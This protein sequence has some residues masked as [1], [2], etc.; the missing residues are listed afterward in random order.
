MV[1]VL[2][3]SKNPVKI[4]ATKEA[5]AHYYAELDVQGVSVASGVPDQPMGEQNYEGAI[6][7]AKNLAAEHEADFYVGIEGG[8]ANEY[9]GWTS[10]GVVCVLDKNGKQGVGTSVHFPLPPVVVQELQKGKE[11]GTVIDEIKQSQNE[12]QKSGA[13][14]F[15]TKDAMSRTD[16]YAPAVISALIPFVQSKV[17]D[18]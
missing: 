3:G 8:I 6:T 7:R 10:F 14:G 16:I 18:Q 17:F 5:F 4:N 1:K 11:L 9:A 15:L 12:K 2:V 13:I